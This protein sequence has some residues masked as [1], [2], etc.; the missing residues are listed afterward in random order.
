MGTD[1][2]GGVEIRPGGPGAPWELA[3]L[4][5]AALP[6]HYD[7]FGLLFGVCNFAG[8]APVAAGRGLPPD[9]SAGLL[10]RQLD[11]EAHD[12][13]WVGWSEL[14]GIDWRARAP[15]VDDRIHEY[16]LTGDGPRRTGKASR[17]MA[18][19]EAAGA[20]ADPRGSSYPEGTEWRSG[21][22]LWRV[23]RL[24]HGDVLRADPDL[25]ALLDGM[26]ALAARH[27]DDNVRL[28]VWFDS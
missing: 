11:A 26:R 16:Q 7:A 2:D 15:R 19:H 3:D 9:A 8:F 28:V 13:S 23:E 21:G 10:D 6:R 22:R 20:D 1:I 4:D 14:A 24:S 27:G 5:L 25:R 17:S 18:W 12:H